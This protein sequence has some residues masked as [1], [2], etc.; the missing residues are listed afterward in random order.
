VLHQEGGFDLD[1]AYITENI[2]AMGFPAGDKSSGLLGY[3]EVL[4]TC[5][6]CEWISLCVLRAFV[7]CVGVARV[8]FVVVFP[9]GGDMGYL[10]M[11]DCRGSIAITW[12]R[13]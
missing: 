10:D 9:G 6:F 13:S 2:I 7:L 4:G 11:C 12:R 5:V 1:M 3:V 8:S